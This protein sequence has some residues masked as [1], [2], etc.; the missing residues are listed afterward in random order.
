M[1]PM[2]LYLTLV[3]ALGGIAT[4]IGAICTA[5]VARRQSNQQRQFL[6]EQAA[7]A[8]R[9]TQLAEE[10]LGEQR[11]SL[12]E[13]NERARLNLEADLMYKLRQQWTSRPYHDYRSKSLQYIKENLRV[14]DEVPPY[15]DGATKEILDFFEK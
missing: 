13:Q 11:R 1:A 7:T 8:Q 12:E 15:I 3:I 9:Q 14:N 4:G 6:Q 2:E 5:T 10:G